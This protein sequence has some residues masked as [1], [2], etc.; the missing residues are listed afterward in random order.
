[1]TLADL[2]KERKVEKRQAGVPTHI[3]NT[4]LKSVPGFC[5]GCYVAA[6]VVGQVEE[7]ILA[8]LAKEQRVEKPQASLQIEVP[9]EPSCAGVVRIRYQWPI[10]IQIEVARCLTE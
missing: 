9:V 2:A 10:R 3:I 4:H 8:D 1:M 6:L 7:S 5:E